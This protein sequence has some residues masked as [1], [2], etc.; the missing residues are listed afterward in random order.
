METAVGHRGGAV[1]GRGEEVVQEHRVGHLVVLG[2]VAF[3]GERRIEE[4]QLVVEGEISLP[5]RRLF[6]VGIGDIDIRGRQRAGGNRLVVHVGAEGDA[7]ELRGG[8]GD[9]GDGAGVGV[10]VGEPDGGVLA[11]EEAD[12]ATELGLALGLE[13]VAETDARSEGGV[14]AVGGVIGGDGAAGVGDKSSR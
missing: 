10:G 6:E 8:R 4:R 12:A 5:D 7:G 2:V 11:L 3:D 9:V 1:G 13:L 14:A